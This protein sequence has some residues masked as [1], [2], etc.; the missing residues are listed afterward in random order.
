MYQQ[1]QEL[2]GLYAVEDR[3]RRL[4]AL[5]SVYGCPR[6]ILFLRDY[7][8]GM[9]IFL[10]EFAS[11]DEARVASDKLGLYPLHNSNIATLT[12]P[13]NLYH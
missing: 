8:K 7:A 3:E 2:R 10:V 1:V 11:V 13:V 12:V 9:D 6:D 5:A 4:F